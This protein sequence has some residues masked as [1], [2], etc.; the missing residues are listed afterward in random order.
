MERDFILSVLRLTSSSFIFPLLESPHAGWPRCC[1]WCLCYSLLRCRAW[2]NHFSKWVWWCVTSSKFVLDVKYKMAYRRSLPSQT[3]RVNLSKL[4]SLHCATAT[5]RVGSTLL[6]LWNDRTETAG[7]TSGAVTGVKFP[8]LLKT[9]LL[10]LNLCATEGVQ[11]LNGLLSAERTLWE[12][13][14]KN[15]P[16]DQY[17]ICNGTRVRHSN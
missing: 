6:L 17:F 2:R 9:F 5:A 15:T 7:T 4:L 11:Q 1:M 12:L 13:T 3:V 10:L 14:W 8:F 16:L